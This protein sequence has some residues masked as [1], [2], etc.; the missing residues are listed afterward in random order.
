MAQKV[1]V[2]CWGPVWSEKVGGC[3]WV[4]NRSGWLLELLTELTISYNAN[5]PLCEIYS[6]DVPAGGPA[7]FVSWISNKYLCHLCTYEHCRTVDK[8]LLLVFRKRDK[9]IFI[10]ICKQIKR[11]FAQNSLLPLELGPTGIQ[12]ANMCTG[13]LNKW[14]C[15]L[16]ADWLSDWVT[17]F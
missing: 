15:H 17:H 9:F 6:Q 1:K 5:L 10:L 8:Q 7:N 4:T 2:Q 16:I 14:P 3:C 12:L 13:Q 11:C